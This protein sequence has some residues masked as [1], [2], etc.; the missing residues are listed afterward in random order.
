MNV[1]ERMNGVSSEVVTDLKKKGIRVL[2]KAYGVDVAN[3]IIE[4]RINMGNYNKYI[5]RDGEKW[6]AIDNS[7]KDA[8][9]EEFHF[10]SAAI[11]WLEN[12]EEMEDIQMFEQAG[13]YNLTRE[14][15]RVI[16]LE[17]SSKQENYR[18]L[19]ASIEAM[20]EYLKTDYDALMADLE[21]M[22]LKSIVDLILDGLS[23]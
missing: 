13:V 16:I 21:K 22:E 15:I 20:E 14:D 11:D 19:N 3:K 17:L 4:E 5:L 6:V 1:T 8:W 2:T 9:V 12:K 18:T 10:W 23:I 7:T